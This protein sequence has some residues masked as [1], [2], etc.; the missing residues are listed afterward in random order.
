MVGFKFFLLEGESEYGNCLASHTYTYNAT[1][2]AAEQNEARH[3][4]LTYAYI[5]QQGLQMIFPLKDLLASYMCVYNATAIYINLI[6]I[7]YFIIAQ[8]HFGITLFRFY[9]KL[10]IIL[11]H[12]QMRTI[13]LYTI[14]CKSGEYICTEYSSLSK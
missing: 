1:V 2:S 10:P 12:N 3:S 7:N 6:D 8:H 11:P 4:H 5:M 14:I 9:I 13:A